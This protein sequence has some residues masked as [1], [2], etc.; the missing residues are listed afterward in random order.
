MSLVKLRA[1]DFTRFPKFHEALAAAVFAELGPGDAIYIPPLWWHHVESL[2]PFNVL[3]NYWWHAA[4]GP[5]IGAASGF[6]ALLHA[7]LDLRTLPAAD[8]EGWRA[9]FEYYVFAPQDGVTEHIPQQ[10]Q[11]ILGRLSPEDIG[12]LRATLAQRLKS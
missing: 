11:G 10:R 2:E 12:R 5:A 7:M 3:V 6:D 9:L 8:R 1:P 4:G